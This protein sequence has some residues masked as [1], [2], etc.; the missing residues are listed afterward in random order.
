MYL[1]S[2]LINLLINQSKKEFTVF[3]PEVYG[4]VIE[5]SIAS[6]MELEKENQLV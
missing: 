2:R 1:N 6:S 5:N 4:R 3:S